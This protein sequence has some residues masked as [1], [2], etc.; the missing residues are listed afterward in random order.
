MAAKDI[1]TGMKVTITDYSDSYVPDNALDNEDDE[2][3][4]DLDE[5]GERVESTG[6]RHYLDR[7]DG[8]DGPATVHE[9]RMP[10]YMGR[11]GGPNSFRDVSIPRFILRPDIPGADVDGGLVGWRHLLATNQSLTYAVGMGMNVNA[12]GNRSS[13]I[14]SSSAEEPLSPASTASRFGGWSTIGGR[15]TMA[16]SPN[17]PVTPLTPSFPSSNTPPWARDTCTG[18]WNHGHTKGKD[19]WFHVERDRPAA[20]EIIEPKQFF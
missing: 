6:L 16:T 4:F 18:H 3:E 13:S 15:S 17:T 12:W 1:E 11:V 9:F 2:S 10:A 5:F 19:W 7:P 14:V 8:T 20:I